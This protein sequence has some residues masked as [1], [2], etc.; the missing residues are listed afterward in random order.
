MYQLKKKQKLVFE[1]EEYKGG[2]MLPESF[3]KHAADFSACVIEVKEEPKKAP[4][5]KAK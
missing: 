3:N 2:D 1:G 5:K 4:A